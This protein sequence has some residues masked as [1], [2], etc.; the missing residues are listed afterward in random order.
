[1]KEVKADAEELGDELL[2]GVPDTSHH[3]L[4]V[5]IVPVVC[6]VPTYQILLAA[7]N[8]ILRDFQDTMAKVCLEE[9]QE[10][11]ICLDKM[12]LGKC[13]R[14]APVIVTQNNISLTF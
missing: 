13:Q 10:C 12:A 4:K 14:S 3:M 1:M 7:L 2:H 8:Q 6:F 9:G 5:W 11:A